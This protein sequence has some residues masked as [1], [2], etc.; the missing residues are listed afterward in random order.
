MNYYGKNLGQR[1]V[2]NKGFYVSSI[3][4]HFLVETRRGFGQHKRDE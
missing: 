2:Q 4:T 3:V 1:Q